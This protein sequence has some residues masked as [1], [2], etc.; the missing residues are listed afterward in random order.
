MF[1]VNN[2]P[3]NAGIVPRV[4]KEI[5]HR[6]ERN[7][8]PEVKY[9]VE[10]AMLEIYMEKLRDLL[11]PKAGELQVARIPAIGTIVK[12]LIGIPV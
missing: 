1:G 3:E 5:F 11:N 2:P 12:G 9:E 10:I 7:E 8:D 6:I 4:C